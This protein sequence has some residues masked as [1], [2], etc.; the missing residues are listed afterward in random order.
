MA[1]PALYFCAHQDD[2]LLQFSTDIMRHIAAG[3]PT[4][5]VLYTDGTGSAANAML[6][7]TQ[8][9]GW[10]GGT[11]SPASEG[12]QPLNDAAFSAARTAEFLSSLGQLGV[13]RENIIVDPLPADQLTTA[14]L[15]DYFRRYAQQFGPASFKTHSRHDLSS[16]HAIAGRALR[17]LAL[18]GEITDARFF[19]SRADI[20]EG[21]VVGKLTTAA[22]AAEMTRISRAISCYYAW[23]PVAGSFA[24]GAHSV[25]PQFNHFKADTRLRYHTA[26]E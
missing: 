26:A 15:T 10:W 16:A 13:P 20:M 4:F 17:D 14:G 1:V 6:N 8:S 19:L 18:A 11:H 12:Y 21:T 2:E 7:G 22:T 9:S 25:H 23:N 24:I 5:V 3:R